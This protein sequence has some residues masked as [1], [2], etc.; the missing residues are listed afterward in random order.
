MND[1]AIKAAGLVKDE[2]EE[3]DSETEDEE[4]DPDASP[5]PRRVIPLDS[6]SDGIASS[7]APSP[8]HENAVASS[9]TGPRVAVSDPLRNERRSSPAKTPF[10]NSAHQSS[11]GSSSSSSIISKPSQSSPSKKRA[12]AAL[13]LS[14]EEEEEGPVIQLGSS[15]KVKERERETFQRLP[16]TN[17]AFSYRSGSSGAGGMFSRGGSAVASGSGGEGAGGAVP[18]PAVK[19]VRRSILDGLG[20]LLG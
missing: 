16:S 3:D 20:D 12:V 1:R 13:D 4:D 19:K 15:Y 7:R 10:S 9:S 2:D 5:P 18:P 17:S 6:S 14:D 11:S 8:S